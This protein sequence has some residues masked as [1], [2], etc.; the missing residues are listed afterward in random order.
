MFKK[1]I[2]ALAS[3]AITFMLLT[4]NAFS[5]EYATIIHSTAVY[6]VN[7]SPD[8]KY[9]V[10]GS[11]DGTTK[12]FDVDTKKCLFTWDKTNKGHS[13]RVRSIGFSPDGN[14]IVSGSE[15]KTLKL[16]DVD[17]KKCLF[18]WNKTNEGHTA[19]V[20]SVDFSPDGKYIVSGSDDT[21]SKLF[22]VK[23]KQCLFTWNQT[24]GGL[25]SYVRSVRFS[26]DNKYIVFGLDDGTIK[27]FDVDTKKCLFTWDQT[28]EGHSDR[29][30]SI[31]FGPG[32]HWFI[33]GSNDNTSKLFDIKTK[34]CLY[35]WDE[36]HGGLS[37][38]I[39]SVGVSPKGDYFV[40]GSIDKT[41]RFFD[42]KTKQC[43]FTR[44]ETNG[45]H[46][47]YI[48]SVNFAP[49]GDYFASC[50]EDKTI[51]IWHGLPKI[52]FSKSKEGKLV[53]KQQQR[54]L[55]PYDTEFSFADDQ[56]SPEEDKA[57]ETIQH[58]LA[59]LDKHKNFIEEMLTSKGKTCFV[60]SKHI[61][62]IKKILQEKIHFKKS[63]DKS[64]VFTLGGS[65][66]KNLEINYPSATTIKIVYSPFF[67]SLKKENKKLV[68]KKISIK[69]K[70][71][72]VYSNEI[73]NDKTIQSRYTRVETYTFSLEEEKE[74]KRKRELD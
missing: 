51:K 63:E 30:N 68:L 16:F 45:G 72:S 26:P 15:D 53:S 32:G 9:L 18:T 10:F 12:L 33:S 43:L 21:T 27:L 1:Y 55:A 74:T 19:E 14:Y 40:S 38:F 34:K 69:N 57:N 6:S 49:N 56:S 61:D 35:T 52:F 7:F 59:E 48:F 2:H 62:T 8:S 25:S 66:D 29:V 41:I 36:T 67:I 50:S 46:I 31:S 44:D 70:D 37:G 54:K 3:T 58:A 11:D 28:N 17:T 23:T 22:D 13:D 73:I 47:S 5:Q 24:N 39:L 60:N 64:T 71:E 4:S 42:V 65:H 20:N